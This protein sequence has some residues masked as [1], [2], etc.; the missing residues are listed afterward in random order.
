MEVY[1]KKK[2]EFHSISKDKERIDVWAKV[3]GKTIYGNDIE[4]DG[5]LY[6]YGVTTKYAFAYIDGIDVTEAEQAK[7]VHCVVTYRD[8]SGDVLMG[9]DVQDQYIMAVDRAITIG[10][11]VAVIVADSLEEAKAAAPLVKVAYR[12]QKAITDMHEALETDIVINP[13]KDDNICSSCFIRKGDMEDIKEKRVLVGATYENSWQEH[14][15]IEPEALIAYPGRRDK[16]V[17]V[18]G[19]MQALYAPVE[20]IHKSLKIPVADITIV[21]SAIG[22]SFGGKLESSEV[23]AV[24]A[25]MA[26]LK[27]RKPVKYVLTREESMQQSHK[28]HPF[29]L[30]TEASATPDGKL[31][32]LKVDSL[33]DAGAYANMSP[34]VI[35]KAVSLGAGPYVIPNVALDS[36]AIY[37]N[38]IPTG[39]MRGFGNPQGILAREC[40]FD[41]LA[42]QLNMSPYEFRKK[43]VMH[44]GDASGS[45]QIIDFEDIGAEEA[46][47]QVAELLEFEEKYWKYR[48]EN[49]G[50]TKR[51]GVGLSL[52][53]RGNSY[54]TGVP[55]VGRCYID[56]KQ[57]GSV[58]LSIGLTEIGQGLHTTM[59]QLTAEALG[60]SDEYVTINESDS[61]RAPM[62]GTCNASRGTF[63]GGN[64]IL[65]SAKRIHQCMKEAIVEIYH[66]EEAEI[67]FEKDEVKFLDQCISFKEAVKITYGLGMTPSFTGSY[68]TPD[69]AFDPVTGKGDTFYEFTYSCIGVEVE[70]DTCTGQTKVLKIVSGHDM[71]RA[72]N[73][74]MACGQITGGAVMA[75]GFAMM[76]DLNMKNGKAQHENFDEYMIPNIMDVPM[77]IVPIIV[78]NPN[79]RGPFGARSLGEPTL[80]PGAGAFLNAVNCA[81]GELGKVRSTPIDI[82]SVLFASK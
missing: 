78:E 67:V 8:I 22:G 53:Y 4:M 15:Y 10:D 39:S 28:R 71:G 80:D 54:G 11:V 44:R 64:A 61:S 23:M 31:V 26:A 69:P 62:T 63:I 35:F 48:A 79:D 72:I 73:P 52:S 1:M 29:I 60:I 43:N 76:E 30:E 3:N 19:T 24:R 13:Y 21:A 66:C 81:L 59:I 38:N 32:S 16:E 56:V 33:A 65:D 6:A 40:I 12:P 42:E 74:K 49:I 51:R 82:E 2:Q 46:L 70:V 14:A 41:E 50:K 57:D 7:G 55:D 17:T 36:K 18:Y 47:D 37:T 25:A 34:G 9:E 75:Q 77:D 45:G 5:M 58:L 68:K 20:T 27:V